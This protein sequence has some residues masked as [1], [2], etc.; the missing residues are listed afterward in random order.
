MKPRSLLP[1]PSSTFRC[2]LA[3]LIDRARIPIVLVVANFVICQFRLSIFV[4][5]SALPFS[6]LD[7]M[8]PI[9]VVVVVVNVLS[10]TCL[11]MKIFENF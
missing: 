3:T 11:G 6:R 5:A 2:V 4:V 8:A 1:D 9:V 7:S 10:R